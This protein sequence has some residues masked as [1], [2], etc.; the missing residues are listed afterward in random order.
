VRQLAQADVGER[1][2]GEFRLQAVER[3]GHG[4]AA[5]EGGARLAA[6]RVGVV[7]LREVAAA[8]VGA[9]PAGDRGRDDHAVALAEVADALADLLDDADALVA[10]D[11]AALHAGQGA[12]DQVQVGAADGAG[13][14]ADDGVGRVL[15]LRL[16]DV[17]EPDVAD[18]VEDDRFHGEPPGTGTGATGPDEGKNRTGTGEPGV[19]SRRVEPAGARPYTRRLTPPGSPANG[20]VS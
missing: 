2:A 15:D 11:R 5:E 8:A 16:L 14:D 13:G 6:V 12:A 20:R 9:V 10:E 3:A 4:R 1:D 19:V 7:A 17:V 18:A